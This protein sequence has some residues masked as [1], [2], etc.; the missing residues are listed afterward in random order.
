M[1]VSE[2]Y[3]HLCGYYNTQFGLKDNIP[4]CTTLKTEITGHGKRWSDM[5]RILMFG[6]YTPFK[7]SPLEVVRTT[8]ATAQQ[9]FH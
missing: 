1:T 3:A 9:Y 7:C 2:R 4:I 5:E 6:I 8:P